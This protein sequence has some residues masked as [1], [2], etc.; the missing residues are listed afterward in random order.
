MRAPE[1][2]PARGPRAG[3]RIANSRGVPG[4]LGCC[5]LTLD[6]GRPVFVSSHH[7]LFGAGGREQE[8]VQVDLETG[9][10]LVSLAR[11]RHGRHGS[12]RV[13]QT[14]VHIDCATAEWDERRLRAAGWQLV[15]EKA[16]QLVGD[17]KWR[18]VAE[19]YDTS[20]L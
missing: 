3:A 6:D 9:R 17:T 7:V 2:V 15:Y 18:F 1:S 20:P 16:W 14:D 12:V 5:G 13:D 19:S 11:T 10:G 4:T 8:L